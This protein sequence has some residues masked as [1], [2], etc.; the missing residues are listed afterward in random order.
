VSAEVSALE[1]ARTRNGTCGRV[2][3]FAI[4]PSVFVTASATV[5][6]SGLVRREPAAM[7]VWAT[8]PKIML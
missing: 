8:D 3:Y 7:T 4:P 6:A 1:D 2:F 5:H